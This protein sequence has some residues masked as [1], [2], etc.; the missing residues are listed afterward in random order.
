[1][2]AT[3][4]AGRRYVPAVDDQSLAQNAAGLVRDGWDLPV[5]AAAPLGGGMNSATAVVDLLNER[6]VLKWVRTTSAA[7]LRAGCDAARRLAQHGLLTGDP[8]TTTTGDL[9][10]L[11]EHG[12]LA[13]LHFVPGKP[14]SP[15]DPGDQRDMALTLAAVHASEATHRSGPFTSDLLLRMAHNVEPWVRPSLDLVLAEYRELPDLTWGLLHADPAPEAFLRQPDGARIALI[16]WSAT[17]YG[18]VLYDVAS[19]LMYLGGRQNAA[20]FWDAYVHHSPAPA[21]ELTEYL[22]VFTSYRAAV[23]AAYFSMRIATQDCTGIA[24]D[25]ENWKGLRDAEQMLRAN[26]ARIGSS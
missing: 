20:P 26:G 7:G 24:H 19:A 9:I 16:D 4:R 15:G 3:G 25:G 13:L 14:L 17:S 21:A 11:T 1:M 23:Q 18:P 5:G 22:S 10:H 8:F 12:A 6:A 2:L